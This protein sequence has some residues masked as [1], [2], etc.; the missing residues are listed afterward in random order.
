M[1]VMTSDLA[2][3]P[4]AAPDQDWLIDRHHLKRRLLLWRLV[5]I[6]LLVLVLGGLALVR[7]SHAVV[8]GPH[9]T[10]IRIS[11]IITYDRPLLEAISHAADDSSVKAVLLEINSPGG[12]VAGGEALHD[13]LA[14]LAARKPLVTTMESVAASAGYMIAAPSAR[15]FARQATL[16]G[17]IG[18]LMQSA[19]LSGLL[20]K[21]GVGSNTIVSGPMKDQP[22]LTAPLSPEGRQMLQ[23]I[24]NDMYDQFVTMVAQ[25]RHMTPEHVRVLADG[26]PYTGRQALALGLVDQIGGEHDARVWL[27]KER[28]VPEDMPVR[29]LHESDGLRK[30]WFGGWLGSLENFVESKLSQSVSIDG[31]WALWQ[32]RL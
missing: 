13:A 28:Q 10:R 18:V 24:V 22:S 15:I 8:S 2:S 4:P 26:R 27:A 11:G 7:V 9:L 5:T 32:P 14:Q 1:A 23:G 29:P 3:R 30:H 31:A 20:G 25:G 6:G 16:T 12:T 21:L 19:E 17:S